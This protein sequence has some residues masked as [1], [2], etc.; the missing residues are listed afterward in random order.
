M[1]VV[2]KSLGVANLDDVDVGQ[3]TIGE[4]KDDS[5]IPKY[6][7]CWQFHIIRG[8][9]D[10]RYNGKTNKIL[11]CLIRKIA[12]LGRA[13]DALG[14]KSCTLD[15]QAQIWNSKE[16]REVVEHELQRI[17]AID[18]HVL[19]VF[20][21][22]IKTILDDAGFTCVTNLEKDAMKITL[23]WT[24]PDVFAPKT[25]IRIL[26]GANDLL[27]KLAGL[28]KGGKFCD[29]TLVAEGTE[30]GAHRL[31]LAANSDVFRRMLLTS[32]KEA[33]T[34]RIELDMKAKNLEKLLDLLYTGRASLTRA[35]AD[36]LLEL[37]HYAHLYALTNIVKVC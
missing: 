37:L 20:A 5:S 28:Q 29:V 1:S 34:G 4:Y 18:T 6:R 13:S 35:T 31:V 32:M 3:Y 33:G 14:K 27:V 22:T 8:K 21:R 11:K 24:S 10:D 16:V 15:L 12:E 9:F 17:P 7:Y 19:E 25:H 26:P 30:F 23:G 36:D 2:Q